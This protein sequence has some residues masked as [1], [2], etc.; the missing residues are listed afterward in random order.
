M[1]S[2]GAGLVEVVE[3]IVAEAGRGFQSLKSK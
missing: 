3:W 2:Q 1:L